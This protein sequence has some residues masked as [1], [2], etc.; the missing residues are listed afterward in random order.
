[1]QPF[2]TVD[3]FFQN[4]HYYCDN[5]PGK[6]NLQTLR[7][8]RRHLDALF[9]RNVYNGVQYFPFG[10][11]TGGIPLPVRGIRILSMFNCPSSPCFSARCAFTAMSVSKSLD[12]FR[13]LNLN[14]NNS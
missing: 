11:K 10:L 4:I 1:L 9:L 2:A 8:R 7:I 14:L 13:N 6:L 5:L 3:F 12:I